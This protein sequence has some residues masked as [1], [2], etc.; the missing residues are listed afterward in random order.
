[1]W[2]VAACAPESFCSPIH[3]PSGATAR[4]FGKPGGLLNS[5]VVFAFRDGFDTDAC[6]ENAVWRSANNNP[7]LTPAPRNSLLVMAVLPKTAVRWDYITVARTSNH[8]GTSP[9]NVTFD[10]IHVEAYVLDLVNNVVL[11]HKV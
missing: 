9:S 2:Y 6:C 11:L 1:M 10:Q 7:V 3:K 4:P 5:V 8:F